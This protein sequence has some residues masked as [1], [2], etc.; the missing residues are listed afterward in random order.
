MVPKLT[1]SQFVGHAV[2]ADF[3]APSLEDLGMLVGNELMKCLDGHSA[4]AEHDPCPGKS[5][6]ISGPSVAFRR[7]D[8]F[9][10]CVTAPRWEIHDMSRAKRRHFEFCIHIDDAATPKRCAAE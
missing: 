5:T 7:M 3:A 10:H 1:L 4:F 8:A 2:S 9:R 6:K